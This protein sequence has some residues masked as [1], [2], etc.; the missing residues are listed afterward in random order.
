MVRGSHWCG[1]LRRIQREHLAGCVSNCFGLFVLVLALALLL[2]PLP[3][4]L[5]STTDNCEAIGSLVSRG[6][7]EFGLDLPQTSLDFGAY[8]SSQAAA[9][10]A[11]K[12]T[13]VQGRTLAPHL[14][15]VLLQ[16]RCC[17]LYLRVGLFNW[18]FT[19]FYGAAIPLWL[20]AAVGFM[21]I[22]GLVLLV[23]VCR[24]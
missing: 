24:R 7:L 9:A 16:I 4:A 18:P 22:F 8:L 23:A 3:A 13:R 2:L 14:Q 11:S 10:E 6:A 17:I 20:N 5:E 1:P 15:S 12:A 21:L 19:A